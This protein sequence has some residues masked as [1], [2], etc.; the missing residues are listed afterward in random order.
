MHPFCIIGKHQA[1]A[2]KARNQ[3]FEFSYCR[4]CRRDM[5]RTRRRWRTVPQGF[6]VV[7]KG[8][9]IGAAQLLFDLPVSGRSLAILPA[10]GPMER[11]RDVAALVSVA[12]RALLWGGVERLHAFGRGLAAALATRRTVPRLPAPG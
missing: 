12:A 10:R 6:R 7:W 2:G 3:G 5:V 11:L 8:D 9:P 4:M 1:A